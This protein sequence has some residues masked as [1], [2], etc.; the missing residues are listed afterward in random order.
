[1]I[2]RRANGPD[3]DKTKG[4]TADEEERRG[5]RRSPRR[6]ARPGASRRAA[7]SSTRAR[8]QRRDQRRRRSTR[9]SAR[10]STRPTTKGGTLRDGQLRRLGLPRPGRHLLRLLLELRPA[11]RP[12]AGRCSSRRPARRAPSSCPTSP[13]ASACPATTAR[14][15]PT[16]CATGV[17]FEDG[18]PITSKDVKYAVERSL[19]KDTFPQRADVLQ[20]LPRPAGLHQPLQGQGPGQAGPQGDRDAGRPD[21]RLPPEASRSPAST[22]SPS[23]PPTIPVPAAKDTGTKYKEHVVSTGPYM[24]QTNQPGKSFTLVR[25]PNWDPATDPNRK[26]LPDKIDV[27]LKRQRRR[28]RQPAARRRPRRRRRRHRRAG[29]RPGQDPRRPDAQGEHRQ[30][31]AGPRS[32]TPS[33][34]GDV[35]PFDNI[36]LPQGRRVRRRPDRLPARLRRRHRWRHRHQP[37]AA[38]RSRATRSSTSTRRR[39]QHG[40]PRQ[41]QGRADRSAASR[42]ASRPTSPTGPSGP[43]RRPPPSRCSSRWRKV[44]IKLTLKPLPAGRLLQALRRQAGLRQG[45]QPRPA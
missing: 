18:T 33:I 9:R 36:A 17:K 32:G 37:D 15:G 1:M 42:T 43:R 45:Q 20:R 44:G 41:G 7:A 5:R 13:R 35:A 3:P 38:D 2:R 27:A 14:P 11:L 31:A 12:L 4:C 34:N 8:H 28:H 25:N 21:D 24:F 16:S 26:A 29:R 6:R 30:P 22:T 10:S 40:R 39:G 23:C 19:D